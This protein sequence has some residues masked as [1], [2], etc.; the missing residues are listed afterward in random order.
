MKTRILAIASLVILAASCAKTTTGYTVKGEVQGLTGMVYLTIFEGKLPTRIDS[1]ESV[2]GSFTF[3]GTRDLP[4]L[5]SIETAQG[6]VTR[7]F[8][9]NSEIQIT[10]SAQAPDQIVVSGSTTDKTYRTYEHGMDSVLQAAYADSASMARP[11]AEDSL[12][13]LLFDR[14]MKFVS[15]NPKSLAAAYVLYREMAYMMTATQL[16]AALILLDPS[17]QGSVYV[18]LVRTMADALQKTAPGKPYIDITLP[19]RDGN[20]VALSSLVGEGKYVLLEFW[21]SWCPPCR[22]ESPGLV[23]AY[24]EFG[25]KGFE[26]YA[27]SL[28]KNKEDWEKG[29]ADLNLGWTHVSNLEFWKSA[30]ADTYGVRSIPANILIGPDGVIMDR[31]LSSEAIR[32]RMA[33]LLKDVK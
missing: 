29:I 10:G 13:G 12:S 18:D 15:D 4:I 20:P 33:V 8:L 27:V 19:G 16:K 14:K 2:G 28:D 23:A 6:P 11:G 22:A 21:A 17:L 9:E 24:K 5:S 30:A 31:N 25:P 26:I 3:T 7:F 1:V 32:N